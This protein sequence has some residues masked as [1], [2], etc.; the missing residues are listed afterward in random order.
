M[1]DKDKLVKQAISHFS[2]GVS[3]D[4]FS[5][6]VTTYAKLA[7]EALKKQVAKK[8][9]WETYEG[10]HCKS[11]GAGVFSYEYFCPMCG[12]AIDWKGCD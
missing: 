5:E 8:P 11:C 6:P 10:W 12:G 7:I 9:Y 4:F 2:H 1:D 3:Y